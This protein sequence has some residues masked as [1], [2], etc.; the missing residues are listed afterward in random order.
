MSSFFF[1]LMLLHLKVKDKKKQRVHPHHTHWIISQ[2]PSTARACQRGSSNCVSQ[3]GDIQIHEPRPAHLQEAKIRSAAGTHCQAVSERTK[4]LP[5]NEEF[6]RIILCNWFPGLWQSLRSVSLSFWDH[7]LRVCNAWGWEEGSELAVGLERRS[8]GREFKYFNISF[9]DEVVKPRM[10]VKMPRATDFFLGKKKL[11]FAK[12][13]T[14]MAFSRITWV[15][16]V[17]LL[18]GLLGQ[19]KGFPIS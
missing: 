8:I 11:S 5:V 13:A 2:I 9:K 12:W 14:A 18:L 19:L 15:L 1:P 16:T 7:L 4:P 6:L 10:A 3:M 17:D